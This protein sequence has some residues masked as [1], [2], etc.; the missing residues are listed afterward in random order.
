MNDRIIERLDGL[1]ALAEEIEK[2]GNPSKCPELLTGFITITEHLYGPGSVY[3]E[4]FFSEKKRIMGYTHNEYDKLALLAKHAHGMLKSFRKDCECGLLTGI[5]SEA[6]A[7]VLAD[8]LA[9]AKDAINNEHKD[10]AA[11]LA[12]A[13]LEDALKKYGAANGL[14]VDNDEMSI[15]IGKLKANGSL[16]GAESK[17]VQSYVQLRNKAFHAE[18]EKLGVSEIQSLIAYLESFITTKLL[19]Q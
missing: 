8:F 5:R 9:L 6:K 13:A 12:C 15:V 18:W 7:E 11:V 16:G 17:V 4:Q 14:L 2:S 19:K 3:Q 10:V 1:V